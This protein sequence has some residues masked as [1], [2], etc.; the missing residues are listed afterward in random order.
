M[1]NAS[2]SAPVA[3]R[4]STRAPIASASATV[5]SPEMS[6][7]RRRSISSTSV[8][9]VTASPSISTSSPRVDARV[10]D[11]KGEGRFHS[12]PTVGRGS[13]GPRPVRTQMPRRDP[14]GIA[15]RGHLAGAVG[16]AQLLGGVAGGDD[17]GAGRA[18]PDPD[19]P[20]DHLRGHHGRRRAGSPGAGLRRV[21]AR[22]RRR[23]QR[24]LLHGAPR[25]PTAGRPLWPLRP[26]GSAAARTRRGADLARGLGEHRRWAG[27]PGR[28]LRD[29]D[30]LR[31]REGALPDLPSGSHRRLVGVHR[32]LPGPRGRLWTDRAGVAA[33]PL[34]GDTPALAAAAR[35]RI[36]APGPALGASRSGAA[37]GVC[38]APEP[39]GRAA[40]RRL[41][42]DGRAGGRPVGHR[43]AR[44]DGGR[45]PP[46]ERRLFPAGLAAPRCRA[47]HR[48]HSGGPLH[49]P[50]G[51][52]GRPGHDLQRAS[53]PLRATPRPPP[54]AGGGRLG[55]ARLRPARGRL[56]AVPLRSA[57]R[58]VR[59]RLVAGRR[60]DRCSSASRWEWWPTPP[61][62][63]TDVCWRSPWRRRPPAGGRRPL[64]AS[65]ARRD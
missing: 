35:R 14:D 5:S 47:R 22:L 48:R 12:Q 37:T 44:G 64:R 31:P 17:R 33:H 20:A 16:E 9:S 63:S 40:G 27:H 54:V 45:A 51:A 41:C 1:A 10:E 36:A 29:G 18:V 26:S 65:S 6:R 60:A 62:P 38:V 19:G 2:T 30:H 52:A 42:R 15:R 8:R 28:A 4:S 46:A 7:S 23:R 21:D 24:A 43:G 3:S 39:R 56:R 34:A 11:G 49:H 59:R 25:G 13:D 32:R 57:R 55:P 61:S 58:L 53:A 50:A